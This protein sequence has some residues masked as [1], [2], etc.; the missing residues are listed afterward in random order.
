MRATQ[1]S[2][3]VALLAALIIGGAAPAAGQTPPAQRTCD[4]EEYRQ[5]DFWLGEWG[6]T[7]RGQPTG[8]SVI[9]SRE[10]GCLIYEQWTDRR[11][12]TGQSMN[13]YDRTDGKWHQVWVA[14]NGSV[15]RLSGGLENGALAYSSEAKRPDGT[16]VLHRLVFTPNP[17]GTV[18]QHWTTSTDD[19][20]TWTDAFDALYRKGAGGG[21]EGG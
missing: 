18:R 7:V 20:K 2:G 11:G 17:D 13:F 6:V 16:R 21:V 9:S 4:G 12:G 19:G 5:F 15:L 3:R 14:S 8:T 10:K 1:W